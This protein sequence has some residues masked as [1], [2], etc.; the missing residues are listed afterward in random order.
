MQALSFGIVISIALSA[1]GAITVSKPVAAQSRID[2]T[3]MH[4]PSM[5]WINGLRTVFAPSASIQLVNAR[6]AGI[7]WNGR[8]GPESINFDNFSDITLDGPTIGF[9]PVQHIT[10]VIPLAAVGLAAPYFAGNSAMVS[11]AYDSTYITSPA[12]S[13]QWHNANTV[14]LATVAWD[15]YQILRKQPINEISDIEQGTYIIPAP[16]S[17]WF[18]GTRLKAE[19]VPI[20]E[21]GTRLKSED[22]EGV[23]A[24]LSLAQSV[25]LLK[26]APHIIQIDLASVPLGFLVAR[27]DKWEALPELTQMALRGSA[28]KYRD[29]MSSIMAV[30]AT[31][32]IQTV[33]LGNGSVERVSADW[34]RSLS[35]EFIDWGS[36]WR[37][38]QGPDGQQVLNAYQNGLKASGQI[39]YRQW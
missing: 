23:I 6:Q 15:S 19:A 33:L 13:T 25:G 2:I 26:Q 27:K 9:F 38:A 12:F 8:F 22:I 3:S 29:Y 14:Y 28:R 32:V 4:P 30:T 34:K 39:S 18:D 36:T 20:P 17:S 24:P 21:L 1:F 16:L 31:Q 5:P 10:R 11:R 7:V 35:E 37:E